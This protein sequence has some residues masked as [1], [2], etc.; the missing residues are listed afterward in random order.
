MP[1][2][3]EKRS[4]DQLIAEMGQISSDLARRQFLARHETLIRAGTV[5]Q[6]SRLVVQKVRVSTF[7]ALNLA[8]AAVLIAK[9]IR[10]KKDLALALRAKANALYSSGDN[11]AAMEHHH[12]AFE[13]YQSLG[14]LQE[15]ARTLST[16]I[17]PTILLGEYDKAFH[18]AG[19]AREIFT[20]LND[21]WRLARLEIN[22]GNIYYRQDRFEEAIAHYE[23][24]L[25]YTSPSPRDLST[26]RMP[27]SA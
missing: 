24:C 19:Q 16:S 12:Q 7:E 14:N 26:S 6:L 22:A 11:R 9:R 17:Q 10:R 2:A 13:L 25:L 27:S 5:D 18:A 1:T 8:E 3:S 20:H 4:L 21:L 15:A 23:R